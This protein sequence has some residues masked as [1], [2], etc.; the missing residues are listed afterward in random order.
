MWIEAVGYIGAILFAFCALPQAIKCYREKN[1]HGVSWLLLW[2]WL[3]GEICVM[4]YT[5]ATLGFINP[6]MLNYAA[7]ILWI[8]IILNYKCFPSRKTRIR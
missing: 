1:A 2:M 4:I 3:G 7:N 8:L 6:L 5:A